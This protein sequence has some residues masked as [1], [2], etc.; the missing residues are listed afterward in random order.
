MIVSV[1]QQF[2]MEPNTVAL[3][4]GYGRSEAGKCG[5]GVGVNVN[6]CLS[7][8]GG[9]TQYYSTDEQLSESLGQE[10]HYSSVQYHHTI[11]VKAKNNKGEVINA[12]EAT[13]GQT[14]YGV[15]L[16]GYQ[17]SLTERSVIYNSTL[18]DLPA[19]LAEMQKKRDAAQHLNDAGLYPFEEYT[20]DKYSQGHHWGMHVDLNSCIGCNACTC[21]LYTSPSPRD[22]Q[23][24]RM[25]SSA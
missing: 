23:K 24:S 9:Y 15:G 22:R 17:G 4:L 14:A 18:N 20:A 2:G 8:D 12:D 25:P 5:T 11:G 1:I 21:L 6:N 7:L 16:T 10:D 3:A 13:L 19:K